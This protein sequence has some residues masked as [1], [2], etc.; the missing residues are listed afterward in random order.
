MLRT[1]RHS[2]GDRWSGYDVMV[3]VLALLEEAEE[4][5]S[6][7]RNDMDCSLVAG[8]GGVRKVLGRVGFARVRKRRKRVNRMK[9][10][11]LSAG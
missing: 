4:P 2:S 3:L 1:A 10:E 7:L 6:A 5:N 8:R 11:S 9:N